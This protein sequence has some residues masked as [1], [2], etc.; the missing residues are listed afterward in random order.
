[1]GMGVWAA[2]VLGLVQGLTEFLPVSSSGHLLLVRE[3][4]DLKVDLL[5]DIILHLATLC[6]VVIVFRRKIWELVKN[7]FSKTAVCLVIATVITCTMVLIFKDWIDRTLTVKVLPFTFLV[8]AIVL[9]GTSLLG[10]RFARN[11][12]ITYRTSVF[13][14]VVQGIAVIPGISRSGSTIAACLYS[15]TERKAAAEF[16]FLMSIPI[17]IASFVYEAVSNPIAVGSVPA[18][19]L[20][21]GFVV[22]LASGIFAIKFMLRI[23]Q[24]VKLYWFS[25]YLVAVAVILIFV[26]YL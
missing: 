7:P 13:A 26:F 21:F 25:A 23:I 18:L 1:M 8:T 11:E 5:F 4:F 3:L 24:S 17:I 15:G 9:F 6:A 20:V 16:S 2:I 22:A 19:P 12:N 14:G 10:E